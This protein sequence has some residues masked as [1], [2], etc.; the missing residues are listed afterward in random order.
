MAHRLNNSRR[1][2]RWRQGFWGLRAPRRDV[3]EALIELRSEGWKIV[4]H[5]TRSEQEI[6]GYLTGHGIP[7]VVG[8]KAANGGRVKTGQ[9]M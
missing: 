7:S 2:I 5:T 3:L 4:I 1:R 8:S 9:R 6:S